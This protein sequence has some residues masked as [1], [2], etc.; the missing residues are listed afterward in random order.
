MCQV[1][2]NTPSAFVHAT[3]HI[4]QCLVS[5]TDSKE[6]QGHNCTAPCALES[7]PW[8]RGLV[9]CHFTNAETHTKPHSV[10]GG[11]GVG[12]VEN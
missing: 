7:H 10:P 9:H 3:S 4:T 1:R 8:Q 11:V 2:Y 5:R 12:G 6:T